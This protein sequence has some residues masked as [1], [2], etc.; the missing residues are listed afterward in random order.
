MVSEMVFLMMDKR[1][2]ML[3][4]QMARLGPHEFVI[5]VIEIIVGPC[6]PLLEEKWGALL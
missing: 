5:A 3:Q 2:D 6:L 1:A 4:R